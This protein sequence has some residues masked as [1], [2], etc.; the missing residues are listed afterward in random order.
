MMDSILKENVTSIKDFERNV[1]RAF[2]DLACQYTKSALKDYDRYLMENRDSKYRHKGKRKTTLKTVYGEVTYK[3]VLYQYKRDDG[4]KGYI[5]LLDEALGLGGHGLMSPN[6]VEQ[7]VTNI[8]ELS[9]RE[10]AKSID[11]MTG[12]SISAMGVWNVIQEIGHK[13]SKDE[14]RL[15]KAHKEGNSPGT[16]E[17]EVLFEEA[18]GTYINLQGKEAKKYKNGKKE[19]K[20]AIAYKGWK[21]TATGRFALEGKVVTAGFNRS[22]VFH[23]IREAN[24]ASMYNLDETRLRLLNGDGASW[25]KKVCDPD[26]I[27][28]LDPY[29]KFK[30]VK[31]KISRKKAQRD[32]YFHLRNS[33]VNALLDYLETYINSLCDDKEIEKARELLT[34]FANNRD[35][36]KPYQE[37][38]ENLPVPPDGLA[39]RNMGAMENHV[40]S[41]IARRMKHNHTSWSIQGGNNLAKILAKKSCGKLN[42]IFEHLCIPKTNTELDT[43]FEVNTTPRDIKQRIGKGYAYPV[44]GSLPALA[45]GIR[46]DGVGFRA[47]AGK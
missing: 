10:C 11:R 21:E 36:L 43:V 17:T 20:V 8:S 46:G 34:Y 31:E 7:I 45:N 13:L 16:V 28:Q 22:S 26:T 5:Y 1:F 40:W 41:V 2:C 38:V 3:R 39:Y 18:D 29:H 32:I 37:R 14:E 35:S 6:L 15:V 24:V 19:L 23:K 44:S 9:Y 33:D 25:I 30:I 27:F 42:D 4:L 12:Q 47:I